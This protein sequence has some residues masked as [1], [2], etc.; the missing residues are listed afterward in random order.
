MLVAEGAVDI[1]GEY[2]LK[3]WDI[4]A[5]VP[6]VREAGGTV[7]TV[8]G[9]EPLADDSILVSNGRLHDRAPRR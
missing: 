2:D 5:L 6:V 7:T 3:P 1:A 9:R 4:A 8:T